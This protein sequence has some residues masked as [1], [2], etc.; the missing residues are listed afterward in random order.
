M[1]E[2]PNIWHQEYK[3]IFHMWSDNSI[4][5]GKKNTNINECLLGSRLILFLILT[6]FLLMHPKNT[7]ALLILAHIP[8]YHDKNET[9]LCHP[10]C[11]S[12]PL[13]PALQPPQCGRTSFWATWTWVDPVTHQLRTL[14]EHQFTCGVSSKSLINNNF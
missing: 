1:A 2:Q 5:C 13:L 4:R 3:T 10:G 6:T 8:D 9:R 14:E 7:L 11:Q 12:A